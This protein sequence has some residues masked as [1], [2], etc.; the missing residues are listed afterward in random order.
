MPSFWVNKALEINFSQTPPLAQELR[1][2]NVSQPAQLVCDP[3][4]NTKRVLE[5]YRLMFSHAEGDSANGTTSVDERIKFTPQI[6]ADIFAQYQLGLRSL[7]LNV[8]STRLYDL[9]HSD[10]KDEDNRLCATFITDLVPSISPVPSYSLDVYYWAQ[11]LESLHKQAISWDATQFPVLLC[12]LNTIELPLPST[13]QEEVHGSEDVQSAGDKTRS[14]VR[15]SAGFPE[16]YGY[17]PICEPKSGTAPFLTIASKTRAD[18]N[19][20]GDKCSLLLQVVENLMT[21]YALGLDRVH[22]LI[23]FKEIRV[24]GPSFI[25]NDLLV[26]P[27][28]AEFFN[29]VN[30][31]N[32][33]LAGIQSQAADDADSVSDSTARA[34]QRSKTTVKRTEKSQN[35]ALNTGLDPTT[36]VWS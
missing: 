34:D 20:T 26:F 1:N 22:L 31:F 21:G 15:N 23:S 25:T 3:H 29:L 24:R 19:R 12:G 11:R 2:L 8:N 6:C 18:Q 36:E 9:L 27:S 10:G 4:E 33:L 17:P 14:F 7:C 28:R 30:R 16:V 32:G 35:G 13:V 5:H